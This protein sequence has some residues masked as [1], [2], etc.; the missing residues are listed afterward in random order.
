[1]PAVRP[2]DEKQVRMCRITDSN[3]REAIQHILPSEIIGTFDKNGTQYKY[4]SNV[5]KY[6]SNVPQ[7]ALEDLPRWAT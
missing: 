7:H 6:V 4:H 3:G 5:L 2:R 1:M